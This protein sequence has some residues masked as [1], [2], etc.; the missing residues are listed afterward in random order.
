[1]YTASAETNANLLEHGIALMQVAGI[2]LLS[3]WTVSRLVDLGGEVRGLSFLAGLVGF[4]AGSWFG[5]LHGLSGGVLL[6]GHP[7][8]P[9]L[10]GV[11]CV[12]M[13]LKLLVLGLA[14]PRW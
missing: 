7:L 9:A 13:I 8:V 10:L 12:G 1:M 6:A 5:S 11:L 2:A 3:G 14:G 4:Y